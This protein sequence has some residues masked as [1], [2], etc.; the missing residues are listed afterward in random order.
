MADVFISYRRGEGAELARLMQLR[1]KERGIGA[2]LDVDDLRPGQ[3]DEALL[4]EIERASSFLLI[5]T[6]GAL[7]RCSSE[8]DWLRREITHALRAKKTIVPLFTSGFEFPP[9]S[10]LPPELRPILVH[11]GVPY[12]HE[13]LDAVVDKIVNYVDTPSSMTEAPA[14]RPATLERQH[15]RREASGSRSQSSVTAIEAG[16]V[17]EAVVRA[18]SMDTV[19]LSLPDNETGR[20]FSPHRRLFLIFMPFRWLTRSYKVGDQLMVRIKRRFSS[21]RYSCELHHG[22][23]GEP[24]TP[25]RPER[26]REPGS[27]QS[28]VARWALVVTDSDVVTT[29]LSVLA[30]AVAVGLA[31][32]TVTDGSYLVAAVA[33][34]AAVAVAALFLVNTYYGGWGSLQLATTFLIVAAVGAGAGYA[35][36]QLEPSTVLWVTLIVVGGAA[37][38]ILLGTYLY[39]AG[40]WPGRSARPRR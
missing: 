10:D 38:G 27:S 16:Q 2:F 11:H 3:F 17:V 30:L 20:I 32:T 6:G 37:F 12:S 18:T 40:R 35:I 23:G 7:D 13:F 24:L 33:S 21:G 29:A 4:A 26:R 22:P 1:L 28:S 14:R 5:L 9:E 19:T 39:Y 25:E 15:R 36:A 8:D 34:V 31:I